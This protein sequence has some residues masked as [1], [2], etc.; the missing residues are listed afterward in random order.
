MTGVILTARG[1]FDA[2]VDLAGVLPGADGDLA[3][4]PIPYGGRVVEL[5]ELFDV[6]GSG[7]E[8]LTIEG[9]DARLDGVGAG[10][11]EGE[12]VVRGDVGA[13]LGHQMERDD[14]V[15]HRGPQR[16]VADVPESRLVVP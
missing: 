4:R 2:R 16:D 7:A 9:G 10:L 11:S 1:D 5:G 15:D 12:I 6:S 3:K 14:E 8:R 13:R